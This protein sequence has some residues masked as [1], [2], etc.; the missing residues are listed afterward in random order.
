[1]R[2]FEEFTLI[3]HLEVQFLPLPP[4]FHHSEHRGSRDGIGTGLVPGGDQLQQKGGQLP[5]RRTHR[6]KKM[7]GQLTMRGRSPRGN[8]ML[9]LDLC[10]KEEKAATVS[11]VCTQSQPF[12]PNHLAHCGSRVGIGTRL[13]PGPFRGRELRLERIYVVRGPIGIASWNWNVSGSGPLGRARAAKNGA[14][15]V[16]GGSDGQILE[17]VERK[18]RAHR[19]VSHLGNIQYAIMRTHAMLYNIMQ[20]AFQDTHTPPC[21]SRRTPGSFGAGIRSPPPLPPPLSSFFRPRFTWNAQ[22]PGEKRP[23]GLS[24]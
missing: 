3:R 12:R 4:L 14:A 19:V 5:R 18:L 16:A 15:P 9:G 1:M 22:K 13:G 6:V 10:L 24:N 11:T 23:R 21:E 20:N 7:E 8:S 17:H 2:T